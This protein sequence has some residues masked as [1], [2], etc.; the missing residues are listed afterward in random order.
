MNK[1][2]DMNCREQALYKLCEYDED[3]D[4]DPILEYIEA[5]ESIIIDSHIPDKK[6]TDRQKEVYN[7][8][9]KIR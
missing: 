4:R 3:G 6:P 5:L 1:F 8:L 9:I 7:I 2:K